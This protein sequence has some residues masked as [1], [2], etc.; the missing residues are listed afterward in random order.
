MIRKIQL[1]A[2]QPAQT[3]RRISFVTE[4]RASCDDIG[5]LIYIIVK[6]EIHR[7]CLLLQNNGELFYALLFCGIG[8]RQRL[9]RFF[10]FHDICMIKFKITGKA[11]IRISDL[12]KRFTNIPFPVGRHL[13]SHIFQ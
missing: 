11:S 4:L 9:I 10:F 5:F 7:G 12:H 2:E 1:C 8:T 13:K 3:D 6:F